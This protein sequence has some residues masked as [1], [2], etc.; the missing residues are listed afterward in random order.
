MK[1]EAFEVMN[2]THPERNDFDGIH[3]DGW[4]PKAKQDAASYLHAVTKFEF[5]IGLVSLY[6][7]LHPL[8]SITQN[9]QGRTIDVVKA[10]SLVQSCIED[11][12][13]LREI[14]D[15]EFKIIYQQAERMATKL[16]VEPAIPRTVARQM[17]RNNVPA[18]TQRITTD[19]S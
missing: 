13:H 7:P 4:D 2:G 8:V 19:V 12:K 18:K 5:I 16:S 11:M 1:L 14:M 15:D 17:H 10:Y 9:L 6:R 3:T